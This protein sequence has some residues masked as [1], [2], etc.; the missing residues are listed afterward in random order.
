MGSGGTWT[1]GG[2]SGRARTPQTVVVVVVAI[3]VGNEIEGDR[4]RLRRPRALVYG[5]EVLRVEH[6]EPRRSVAAALVVAFDA[7]YC[8]PLALLQTISY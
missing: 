4:G 1:G 5:L 7:I 6:L 8:S 2:A 3:A